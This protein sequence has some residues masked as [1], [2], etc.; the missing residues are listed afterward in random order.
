MRELEPFLRDP[1]SEVRLRAVLAAGRKGGPDG[2]AAL[3]LAAR[4]PEA[5]VREAAAFAMGIAGDP[6][7]A[8]DALLMTNRVGATI[9]E[10]ARAAAAAIHAGGERVWREERFVALFSS[11]NSAVRRAGWRALV[12][13]VRSW[14]EKPEAVPEWMI[15]PLER[16]G[17]GDAM[18]RQAA[19]LALRGLAP[20]LPTDEKSLEAAR[21]ALGTPT[22]LRIREA[23][24]ER[25]SREQ[26]QDALGAAALSLGA[27]GPD[28]PEMWSSHLQT[29]RDPRTRAGAVRGM[30]RSGDLGSILWLTILLG[31]GMDG[32][33]KERD[34]LADPD[35][36]VRAAVCESLGSKKE[37]VRAAVPALVRTAAEDPSRLVRVA[38]VTALHAVGGDQARKAVEAAMRSEDPFLRAA[39]A[40]SL[41]TVPELAALAA[42]PEVRVRE[43]AVD[44]AGKRKAEAAIMLIEAVQDPDPVVAATA[45]A[46]LG[47]NEIKDGIGDLEDALG[48]NPSPTVA[49]D[50]GADLRAAA[51]EALGKLKAPSAKGLAEGYL[52]DPDPSVRAAAAKVIEEIT[53][54]KPELP[55]VARLRPFP[56][57]AALT[58]RDEGAP[59]V[60]FETDRGAFVVQ[61]LPSAA[62]VHVARFLERVRAG[63]YDGTIFH[64]IVP[65]FVVQGGDPRGDGSGSGG[66]T[67]REEFS[68]VPYE[69]GVL[70][71]PR[72]DH[73]DSGGCQLFFCHGS[74]PHLDQR[75]TVF[76]RIVEG[77]DV[78]DRI[79]LGDRILSAKVVK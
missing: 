30:G 6:D 60:R 59:R 28:G 5:R 20:P 64:R 7:L 40:G 47:E 51:L 41:L 70:G 32:Q 50:L 49:P 35:L 29:M 31:Y 17:D 16:T 74:T 22:A 2:S 46:A 15:R 52:G 25:L 38:A 21:R 56:D 68:A 58:I 75:Y 1:D 61:T 48:R 54:K 13:A 23:L 14:K 65:A 4:D 67:I 26:D 3:R 43:A 79:D 53:G 34:G 10:A 76:G 57:R 27:W 33:S 12:G 24:G 42:D 39:S 77:V 66:D 19:A 55:Q 63:G 44:E 69:R 73:P 71:M 9:E 18:V 8:G 37:F 45:A 78:I 72:S 62:P 36:G 11:D